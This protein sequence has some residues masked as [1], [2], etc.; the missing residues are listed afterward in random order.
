MSPRGVI[1][2]STRRLDPPSTRART[3]AM[4]TAEDETMSDPAR[5]DERVMLLRDPLAA[6]A[7]SR[8]IDGDAFR[9][10]PRR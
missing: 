5:A 1:D 9:A 4:R 7:S 3:T 10:S 2:G 8:P 6:L